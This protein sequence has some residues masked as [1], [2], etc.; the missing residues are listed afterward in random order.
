VFRLL[1]YKLVQRGPSFPESLE[2]SLTRDP[3]AYSAR[4]RSRDGKEVSSQ[5]ALDVP[6]DL[7]N[8]MLGLFLRNLPGGGSENVQI[9]AFTPK[10]RF[11][12]VLLGP[13]FDVRWVRELLCHGAVGGE[14]NEG[15]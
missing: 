6:A 2:A 7:A 1:S 9:V 3:P 8:G 10:P 12:A 11:L 5:G 14:R 15:R 4:T 13:A